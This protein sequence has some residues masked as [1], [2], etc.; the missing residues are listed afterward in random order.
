M[1]VSFYVNLTY[2]WSLIKKGYNNPTIFLNIELVSYAFKRE[3][4]F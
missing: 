4:H 1:E 3:Q 2:I